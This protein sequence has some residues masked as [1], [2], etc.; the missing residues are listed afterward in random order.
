MCPDA[1]TE[2]LKLFLAA[3]YAGANW[4]VV[5]RVSDE[6]RDGA[7]FIAVRTPDARFGV[8]EVNAT[9]A[10]DR[11]GRPLPEVWSRWA[12]RAFEDARHGMTARTGVLRG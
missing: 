11:L 1:F 4:R 8:V 9:D 2:Q 12:T 10:M 7:L 3:R 6:A 5:P